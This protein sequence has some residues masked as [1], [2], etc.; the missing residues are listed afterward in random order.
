MSKTSLFLVAVLSAVF[1]S[2]CQQANPTLINSTSQPRDNRQVTKHVETN[3][4]NSN[5]NSTNLNASDS[6]MMNTN[7]NNHPEMNRESRTNTGN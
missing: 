7:S 1:F 3:R 4:V 5:A 2:A 6:N